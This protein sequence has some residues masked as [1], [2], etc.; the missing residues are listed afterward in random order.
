MEEKIRFLN[1]VWRGV[2]MAEQTKREIEKCGEDDGFA[3]TWHK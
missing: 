2:W 3:D 1:M